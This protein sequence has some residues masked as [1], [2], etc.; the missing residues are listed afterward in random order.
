MAEPGL[1]KRIVA[2]SRRMTALG[3]NQGA[4]GNVS[5]RLGDRAGPGFLITP[6]ALAYEAMS[7]GDIVKI[8]A[9]GKASG[10]RTPSSEWRIHHDIYEARADAGA[11]VHTHSVQATALA[12]LG[13]AIP[14]FHYMVAAA[15]GDSIRC[16]PYAVFGSQA[17]SDAA[18]GALAERS[19]CLLA[20][21]G[22]IALG[23]DLD[24]ALSLA[25]EVE[26]LAA[27]YLAAL[28]AGT[29]KNLSKKQ[30]AE[31]LARFVRYRAGQPVGGNAP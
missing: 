3:I 7:A 2:V 6:S 31:V 15:G 26:T 17:L 23:A 28:G 20:H 16:A 22:V 9:A 21:H 1:R 12:C 5:A 29:P 19:A 24:A 13:R 8:S 11:I 27:Q 4:S 14:A 25:V 10:A 30:M 18:L